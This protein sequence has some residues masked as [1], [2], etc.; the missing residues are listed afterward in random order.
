MKRL[1]AIVLGISK[2]SLAS[3]QKFAE[4]FDLPFVLLSNPK[5][6]VMKNYQALGK[7]MMYGKTVEGTIRSTGVIDPK[8]NI[9]KHWPTIKKAEQH[10]HEVLAFLRGQAGK[11]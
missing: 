1:G 5:S 9:I 6:D 2:D 3:H 8:G 4:K 10:P 7:K 11:D